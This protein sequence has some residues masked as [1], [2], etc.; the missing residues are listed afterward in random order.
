MF[1]FP[2]RVAVV[3]VVGV[4][5]LRSVAAPSAPLPVDEAVRAKAAALLHDPASPVL[6]NPRGDVVV[7]E[8]FDYAC[9]YC[10][11][12]EPKLEALLKSD[13]GVQLIL[14]EFP[15]LTPESLIAA[16][17]SLASV[18]Q[19]KYVQFHQ[20][21]M[22]YKGR[23]EES[24]IFDTAKSVGLDVDRLRKDMATPEIANEIIATFNLARS[25]RI[26]QTPGLIVDTHIL[27]EPVAQ[28]DFQ[29]V[30]AA[31]RSK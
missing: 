25:L 19:E 1:P 27:T 12:I 23:W 4:F 22:G 8:F 11:A 29:K 10:K 3:G 26:F 13:N 28:I 15:I 24:V 9:P 21:L 5:L 30:I 6:G 7:I 17:A 14:K 20:S 2:V 31:A 18:K 16:K